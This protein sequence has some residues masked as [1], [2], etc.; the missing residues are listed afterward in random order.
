MFK[1][2]QVFTQFLEKL[3]SHD[4]I[5]FIIFRLSPDLSLAER[6]ESQ[7]FIQAAPKNHLPPPT[8]DKPVIDRNEHSEC[9]QAN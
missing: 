1:K 5:R 7:S 4:S 8:N 6:T 3:F 9:R 2:W